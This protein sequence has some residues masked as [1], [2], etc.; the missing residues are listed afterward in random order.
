M[1]ITAELTNADHSMDVDSDPGNPRSRRNWRAQS[2]K[3]HSQKKKK[4]TLSL[5]KKEKTSADCHLITP[6]LRSGA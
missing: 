2:G 3:L 4:K 6:V 5:F 1:E